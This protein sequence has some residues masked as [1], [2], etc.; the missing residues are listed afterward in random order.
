MR[1]IVLTN[2]AAAL[3]DRGFSDSEIMR[4]IGSSG[5][6]KIAE[7]L[8]EPR[9][10]KTAYDHFISGFYTAFEDRGLPKEYALIGLIK[11][12]ESDESLQEPVLFHSLDLYFQNYPAFKKFALDLWGLSKKP[13]VLEGAGGTKWEPY[14]TGSLVDN[15]PT[16]QAQIISTFKPKF[17][18]YFDNPDEGE[19][20]WSST[21]GKGLLPRELFKRMPKPDASNTAGTPTNSLYTNI[22]SNL[23][24]KFSDPSVRGIYFPTAY[25]GN[26]E[27]LK[28]W[29]FPLYNP[30]GIPGGEYLYMLGKSEL[31]WLIPIL[32]S[33]AGIGIG[34]NEWLGRVGGGLLGGIGGLLLL[35]YFLTGKFGLPRKFMSFFYPELGATTPR[36]ASQPMSPSVQQPVSAS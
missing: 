18:E 35:N 15:V 8:S 29:K 25:T 30:S 36:L 26:A 33:A 13:A 27:D 31:G 21:L 23:D 14:S 2:M 12:A 19:H 32:L 4:I 34:G 6:D 7:V 17:M 11:A 28:D 5:M 3:I 20:Y 10:K 16:L 1:S 22:Y 24:K 9:M